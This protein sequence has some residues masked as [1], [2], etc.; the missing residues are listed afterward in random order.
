MRN[1]IILQ[2]TLGMHRDAHRDDNKMMA[3]QKNASTI[4]SLAVNDKKFHESKEEI[5]FSKF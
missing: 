3:H 1:A 5:I 2:S 4:V